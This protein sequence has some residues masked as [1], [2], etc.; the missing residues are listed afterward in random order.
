MT[1]SSCFALVDCNNFYVSCERIFR[2]DL[3]HRPVAVLS[4]NDGCVVAR[5]QEVKDLGVKMGTPVFQIKHLIKRHNVQLFS[6]NYAFY[7]DMSARVMSLLA[8]FAPA[9]EVYSIDEAFLDLTGI[10][11]DPVQY[12]LKIRQAVLQQTGITVCAGMGPTKTLAKLA[13]FAAKKWPKTGGVVDL[14]CPLRREKLMRMTPVNEVWGIGPRLHKRLQQ[15]GINTVWELTQQPVDWLH[16]QF[17]VV[18]ART[19][20]ELNGASCLALEEIASARQ[21]I[22]CSRSFKCKLT[23][24]DELAEALAEFCSRAAGKLRQQQCVAG[25]ISVVIQT[26]PNS[27]QDP[28]YQRTAT[29]NLSAAT[30]DTRRIVSVAKGLLQEIYK[31]GYRYAKC[32]VLLS[33][34]RPARQL[35]QLDLF[36]PGS[37]SSAV[38]MQTIDQINRRYQ[39]KAISVAATGL[40]QRW[41]V[42]LENVSPH[43]TTDWQQL[44][45]VKCC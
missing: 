9:M 17:N 32:A 44:P 41:Q 26:N 30:Q 34:I 8:G 15:L 28:Y 33:N 19:V 36:T 31:A 20:M 38:L 25:T 10:T 12:A 6:S 43:Y 21:Q 7:A 5:S 37:D 3:S 13:N 27:K 18:L 2:P 42:P 16:T 24:C 1:N 22:V 40:K 29:Q 45:L 11:E 4:N 35:E 14:G 23:E 39:H